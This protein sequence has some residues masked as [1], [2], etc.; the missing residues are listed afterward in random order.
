MVVATTAFASAASL[1]LSTNTLG[2]GS[3]NVQT[4][5]SDGVSATYT[6]TSGNVTAVTIDGIAA[7]CA[8]GR[9]KV[10]LADSSGAAIGSG[11][12]TVV[13]ATSES[14]SVNPQP[15]AANVAQLHVVIEGP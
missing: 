11:G 10:T 14:V 3:A 2:A 12:P 7:A 4:C 15:A 5:D 6:V 13:A 1:G 8:G 9:L